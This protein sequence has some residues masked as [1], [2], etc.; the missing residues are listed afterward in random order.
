MQSH[1]QYKLLKIRLLN[2]DPIVSFH[3][4]VKFNNQ[5]F[6]AL[7]KVLLNAITRGHRGSETILVDL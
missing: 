4:F 3:K 5:M 7:A 2:R 1:T 6:F